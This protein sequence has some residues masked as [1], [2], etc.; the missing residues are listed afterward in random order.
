MSVK[1]PRIKLKNKK[2]QEPLTIE[3]RLTQAEKVA[4]ALQKARLGD[5]ITYMSHPWRIIW[6]NM[7]IG[8]SRG[9]GLTLGFA[10]VIVITIKILTLMI[11]W[12]FP[13]LSDVSQELLDVMKTTPGLEKFSSV[14]DKT[15]ESHEAQMDMISQE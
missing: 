14:I 6:T 13:W 10:V 1:I 5:Y 9:V 15:I 2:A 12:K 7:L 4:A 8:I 11:S 3:Q